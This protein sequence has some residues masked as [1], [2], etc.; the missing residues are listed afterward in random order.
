MALMASVLLT[1]GQEAP[2]EPD[3][4]W[5]A[6]GGRGASESYRSESAIAQSGPAGVTANSRWVNYS[7]FLDAL[8]M[9][10]E[11]DTDA[12]GLCDENDFDDD[13]DGLGDLSE[14]A[15]TSFDPATVTDPLRRDSDGDGSGDGE[16]ALAGSDPLDPEA[17]L[18]ILAIRPDAG[19]AALSWTARG[20]YLYDVLRAV[21][22][23][24]FDGGAVTSSTVRAEGGETPWFATEAAVTN[25]VGE[26]ATVFFRIKAK[27]P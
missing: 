1:A 9:D 4:V 20:G 13:A 26:A 11:R 21:Q 14:L 7:G 6:A 22:A 15:G 5:E 8:V 10:P 3:R 16:E 2:T 24:G 27:G 18:R 23:G 25:S 17:Y 19:G 12:D